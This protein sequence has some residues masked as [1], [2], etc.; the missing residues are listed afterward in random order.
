MSPRKKN[1]LAKIYKPQN[2]Y[3]LEF[4][5]YSQEQLPMVQIQIKIHTFQRS[6]R[7]IVITSELQINILKKI[8]IIKP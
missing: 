4:N 2:I 7:K 6:Q 1:P 8:I 3:R 5:V